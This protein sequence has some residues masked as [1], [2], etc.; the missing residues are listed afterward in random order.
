MITLGSVRRTITPLRWAYPFV[1]KDEFLACMKRFGKG[2]YNDV[3]HLSPHTMMHIDNG[4]VMPNGVLHSPTDL[5]ARAS[6]HNG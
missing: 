6:R 2:A 4:F 1:N 5:F 3:R